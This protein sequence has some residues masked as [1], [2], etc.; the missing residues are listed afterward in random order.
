MIHRVR[1]LFAVLW[2]C[3]GPLHAGLDTA[4]LEAVLGVKGTIEGDEFKIALPQKDLAV[5]VDG[6]SIVP[7]MGLTSWVAFTPHKRHVMAMGSPVSAFLGFNTWMTF[8]GT[9]EKAAVSGDFAMLEQEVDG[10]IREL[11]SHGIEVTAVHNHMVTEKPKIF[12]LH[13]WGVD[14]PAN[15]AR[16]LRAALDKT[17]KRGKP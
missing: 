10:V 15:L 17:G 6:F 3:A 14:A 11:V 5:T 7:A 4:S 9:K 1:V 12:F 16:G 13:F 8:Q 2:F